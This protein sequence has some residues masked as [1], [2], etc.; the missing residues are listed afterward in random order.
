VLTTAVEGK[1]KDKDKDKEQEEKKKEAS[2][3]VSTVLP[4]ICEVSAQLLT[5]DPT[6]QPH[7]R[8]PVSRPL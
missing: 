8:K 4:M 2:A 5:R 7:Q 6:T 1:D 3:P